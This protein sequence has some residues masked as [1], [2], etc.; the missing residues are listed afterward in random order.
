MGLAEPLGW[1]GLRQIMS[2]LVRL[3]VARPSLRPNTND[4]TLLPYFPGVIPRGPIQ[5]KP[6]MHQIN[7][8]KGGPAGLHTGFII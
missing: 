2:G 4:V 5:L 1:A 7:W 3:P 8:I 6:L